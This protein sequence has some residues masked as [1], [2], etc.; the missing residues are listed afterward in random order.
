[1]TEIHQNQIPTNAG[2]RLPRQ[3]RRVAIPVPGA[4]NFKE[5]MFYVRLQVLKDWYDFHNRV[6]HS[7]RNADITQRYPATE[8]YYDI[9]GNLENPYQLVLYRRG[10]SPYTDYRIPHFR[11]HRNFHGCCFFE[12]LMLDMLCTIKEN[13]RLV[14]TN[15]PDRY[16]YLDTLGFP[17]QQRGPISSRGYVETDFHHEGVSHC[18]LVIEAQS[19]FHY[20][21][22]LRSYLQHRDLRFA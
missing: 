7:Q 15:L 19:R 5:V 17:I 8:T 3:M 1:M 10:F 2:L 12:A 9:F 16:S 21:N 11:V 6:L 4:R 14:F 22:A 13:E 18:A 20:I